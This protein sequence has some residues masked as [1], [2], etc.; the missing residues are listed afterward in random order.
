[1]MPMNYELIDDE[2]LKLLLHSLQYRIQM[3]NSDN[4]QITD[5]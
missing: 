1:M 5:I 3:I 2:I 4:G